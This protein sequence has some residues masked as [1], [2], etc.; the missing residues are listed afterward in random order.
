MDADLKL[1][2]KF[3]KGDIS[4]FEKIINKYK[5]RVINI[6]YRYLQDRFKAEDIAQEV[7]IKVYNSAKNYKPK[8]KLFT[9]IYKITINLCLNEIRSRKHFKTI[10]LEKMSKLPDPT[11]Y[12]PVEN[13]EKDELKYLIRDAIAS[14]PDRQSMVVILKNYEGLSY[15]KISVIMGCSLSA[16]NSLL[17]RAK[18][19]LRHKLTPFF[20]NKTD[21]FF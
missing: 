14:L 9:W 8:A 1:M 20:K 11:Y 6:A 13:L 2:L 12:D 3:K 7:F 21:S 18:Q 19:K 17:Q 10:Y 16:I 4:A 15:Q 5:K